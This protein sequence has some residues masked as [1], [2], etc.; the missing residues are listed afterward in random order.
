MKINK[1]ALGTVQFGLDY[2]IANKRGKTPFREIKSILELCRNNGIS[3]LDTASAY[4]DAEHLM[5]VA[6][7]ADFKVVSKFLPNS[8]KDALEK[9]LA[10]TLLNLKTEQLYGYLAHRPVEL[11]KQPWEWTL[12]QEKKASGTIQKLGFSL[13]KPT[14]LHALLDNDLIPD[15][16]QVPYN[17]LDRRF[18]A[19]LE[20]LKKEGIEIHA[21]SSFLQGLLFMD[22]QQLSSFFEPIKPVLADLKK[23]PNLIGE[24]LNFVI[25]SGL[26][27]RVIIGVESLAQLQENI[28][29][30]AFTGDRLNRQIPTIEEKILIPSNWPK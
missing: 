24:L 17:Y 28:K 20:I 2:G 25:A 4:G 29:S 10:A 5:G 11:L 18:E 22:P 23:T 30:L 6:G 26:V 15:L 14:D 21:R 8:G 9:Q 7:I 1:L 19:D 3:L 13:E 27:D 12:L 16:I